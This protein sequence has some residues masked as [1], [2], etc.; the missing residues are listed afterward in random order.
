MPIDRQWEL[1]ISRGMQGFRAVG[2]VA[3]GRPRGLWT[4]TVFRMEGP[5]GALIS[6]GIAQERHAERASPLALPQKLSMSTA[7]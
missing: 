6:I 5:F 2:R 3:L 7:P 4:L 1:P